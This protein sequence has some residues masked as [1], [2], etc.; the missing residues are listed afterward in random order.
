[1]ASHLVI[2]I[3]SA[4]KFADERQT[5]AAAKVWAVLVGLIATV[6]L[7]FLSLVWAI[8]GSSPRFLAYVC[9]YD[10][11]FI[12]LLFL[13]RSGRTQLS[14]GL[15]VAAIAAVLSVSAWTAGGVR[16]PGMMAYLLLI[17]IAGI[18]QGPRAAALTGAIG[19]AISLGMLGAELTGH[20]P[21]PSVRHTSTSIWVVLIF[22]MAEFVM[23][24]VVVG[25]VVRRAEEQSRASASEHQKA[26]AARRE[27]EEKFAKVFRASPDAMAISELETGRIV[28]ANASYLSL[29]G[30]SREELVGSTTLE[31]DIYDD[32]RDRQRL[33]DTI[34]AQGA[35]RDS[36]LR[37]RTRQRSVITI[38]YSG[39]LTELGGRPHLV[40]VIHDITERKQAEGRERRARD[41]FTRRLIA[42]QEAERR[43][44]AGE[45]HDS[46][47]QNLILIKNRAQLALE[48]A[49]ASPE[50]CRQFQNLQDMA[51]QAIAEVRQISH[52]LRPHQL[53][54]LGLTRALEAMIDGAARNS[55]FP[56][57]H[58]LDAVD[59]LFAPEA[60]THLYRVA[61]ESLSNILKHARARSA[62]VGLERD[63]R[64]V[65]LWIEDDGQGFTTVS[66]KVGPPIEGLGLSSIT[67]RVRILGG[68]LQIDSVAGRGTRIEVAVPHAGES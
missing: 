35:I 1:V 28:E 38:L 12:G 47:G 55:Q 57:T 33:I 52:D 49:A 24:Q 40:S 45:L 3:F 17:G 16:A 53:D 68:T 62:R 60:A 18:L 36:E 2:R 30:Y 56:I 6:S 27:S 31:L 43:R 44:I 7:L 50:M 42:S 25:W 66:P 58:K 51:A 63:V 15:L 10:A 29:F 48:M 67:E 8:P 13:N 65:R 11:T 32:P 23:V 4:P 39:E 21:S 37:F 22:L 5:L 14:A 54:Q 64:E 9:L 26:E 59:D 34:V 61:Q 41:E 19:G 20:L 46:L